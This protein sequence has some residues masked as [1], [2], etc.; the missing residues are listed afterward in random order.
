HAIGQVAHFD[1]E[2]SIDQYRFLYAI[3]GILPPTVRVLGYGETNSDF[4]AQYSAKK[5][6]YWYDF[7]LASYH[8]PWTHGRR[9]R[10][11]ALRMNLIWNACEKLM[12]THDFIAFRN[13]NNNNR[14]RER[15]TVRT[16]FKINLK[17]IPGGCR[18]AIEGDG[19]L[20]KMVRNLVG[21]L[22]AINE[23]KMQSKDIEEMLSTGKRTF[24]FLTAPAKGLYLRSVT[25]SPN[26]EWDGIEQYNLD[27]WI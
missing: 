19:F 22:L 20:Y 14:Q 5:K 21:A 27:S 23:G 25:Y 11:P 8:L 1:H 15:D 26:L 24:Q 17:S 13:S 4:H 9:L 3:N 12:G 10:V 2:R 7:H 16:L 6:T 18:I